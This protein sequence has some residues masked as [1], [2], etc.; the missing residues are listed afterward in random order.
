M[1]SMEAQTLQTVESV[2]KQHCAGLE[3]ALGE[4][5]RELR[6]LVRLDEYHRHGRD[7]EEL[8]R[9]LG[10]L[11]REQLDLGSLSRTLEGGMPTQA[12][13]EERLARI[14]ALVPQLQRMTDTWSTA[15]LEDSHA[16]LDDDEVEVVRRAEAHFDRLTAVFRLLRATQLEIRSKYEP[17][18]HDRVFAELDWRQLGPGELRLSPPFVVTANFDTDPRARTRQIIALLETGMPI[19]FIAVRTGVRG[20]PVVA[21]GGGLSLGLTLETLPLAMWGVYFVQTPWG[22][23]DFEQ[24]LFAALESPRPAVISVLCPR[25]DEDVSSFNTRAERALRARA[26]PS[27]VYDPDRSERLGLCLDLAS[28][29]E[30]EVAWTTDKLLGRNGEGEPIEVDE[31]FTFAH[32]AATEPGFETDFSGPPEIADGLV[33]LT[34]YMALSRQQRVGKLPFI[35]RF[36]D[37]ERLFYEIVSEDLVRRCSERLHVWRTLQEISGTDNPHVNR[38]RDALERKLGGQQAERLEHLRGELEKEAANRE[39]AAVASAVRKLVARLTGVDPAS[40]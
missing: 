9:T 36:D 12:M 33:A 4:V 29:P 20:Q 37:D 23:P 3:Q 11:A 15:R 7:P 2:W 14:Q 28:N 30:P 10:P 34:D 26:F 22:T 40:N 25:T 6:D 8:A 18:I 17:E 24:R 16:T 13:P 31:P 1:A 38:T 35:R 5:S 21:G 32:F 39:R 27:C 19:K